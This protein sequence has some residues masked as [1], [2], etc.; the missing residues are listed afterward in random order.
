MIHLIKLLSVCA[1]KQPKMTRKLIDFYDN[2][3]KVKKQKTLY[4]LS[5][6]VTDSLIKS[7]ETGWKLLRF[8]LRCETDIVVL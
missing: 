4:R 2:V 8:I 5:L 7:H 1:N 6:M 3:C